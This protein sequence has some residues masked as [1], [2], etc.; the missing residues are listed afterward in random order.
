[1]NK[2]FSIILSAFLTLTLFQ[3]AH[4]ETYDQCRDKVLAPLS[5]SGFGRSTYADELVEINCSYLLDPI[6]SYSTYPYSLYSS[7]A[8]S[9]HGGVDCSAG[10]HFDGSAICNDGWVD[11]SVFYSNIEKC[12]YS[13]VGEKAIWEVY[14][15]TLDAY[16]SEFSTGI[17][18]INADD[19]V[20]Y[21]EAI[22]MLALIQ[23]R[24]DQA[25]SDRD[26]F[27]D[28]QESIYTYNV[29]TAEIIYD[30]YSI[31]LD[32]VI[33][34]QSFYRDY[35]SLLDSFCDGSF[36]RYDVM[37]GYC[38][39]TN[40]TYY[41]DAGEDCIALDNL[42]KAKFGRNTRG[43][44]DWGTCACKDGFALDSSGECITVTKTSSEL[45]DVI[46]IASTLVFEGSGESVYDLNY[47]EEV[48]SSSEV[49]SVSSFTDVS[50][51]NK[52]FSAISF[53][54]ATE[55]VDGYS[56]GSYKPDNK[57]NRAEFTKILA[58]ARYPDEVKKYP[59]ES[60]FGDVGSSEW[61]SSFVCF[62]KTASMLGGYPD[63]TFRPGQNINAAE[64]LKITLEAYYD[65]IPDVAGA[66]YQKYW[67]YA[68]SN[69]LIP[70]AWLDPSVEITRGEMA[71]L[72]YRIAE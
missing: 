62:A 41:D 29:L 67:D 55:I 37:A 48:E 6:P 24:I 66:W 8:C 54:K 70:S 45:T 17:N 25:R 50:S 53:V 59:G 52:Y 71:E 13:E 61:F 49:G 7:G 18:L 32:L 65:S 26:L 16:I 69:G 33:P 38:S 43:D 4:A 72:I 47:K 23:S 46:Y 31:F 11:S 10:P 58:N 35:M 39:C 64:A 40:G 51:A 57:I 27:E 15:D 60:C 42:C 68:T 22:D 3:N 44:R 9:Y 19:K 30:S 5:A 14:I 1:M 20:T 34:T 36:Q 28:W 2:C 21:E 56:D 63:G 12:K